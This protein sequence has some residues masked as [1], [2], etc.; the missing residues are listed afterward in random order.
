MN[1]D[2][3]GAIGEVVGAIAVVV[4]LIYLAVQIRQ[5][6]SSIRA[7]TLQSN[8]NVWASTFTAIA[9][10]ELARVYAIGSLGS[11]EAKPI[12]YTQ[13]FFLCKAMF[14]GFEDQYYQYRQGTLDENIYLGYERSIALQALAFPGVQ[15]WWRQTRD[16]YSPEFVARIDKMIAEVPLANVND[17]YVEWQEF[18]REITASKTTEKS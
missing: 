7:S 5:N 17:S 8:T 12:A 3:L 4:T 15:A 13:F 10:E 9:D 1:W 18:A 6:T 14:V 11:P 2:A 16:T